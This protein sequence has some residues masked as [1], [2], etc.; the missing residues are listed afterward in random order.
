MES[1]NG[2]TLRLRSKVTR[3][4]KKGDSALLDGLQIDHNHTRSHITL[5]GMPGEAAGI[6]TED[7]PWREII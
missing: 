4:L 6:H 2:N 5:D 3:G 1:F 7:N